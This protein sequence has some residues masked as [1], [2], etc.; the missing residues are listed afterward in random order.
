M[1]VTILSLSGCA[2]VS[3]VKK[4]EDDAKSACAQYLKVQA[5]D[6]TVDSVINAMMSAEYYAVNAANANDDY[7][8]LGSASKALT[9][10]LSIGSEDLAQSA[11]ANVARIC[12]DLF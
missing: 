9:E 6:V 3:L 4:G 12:N 8:L 5:Q 1:L 10:S 11:W 7:Q 2:G